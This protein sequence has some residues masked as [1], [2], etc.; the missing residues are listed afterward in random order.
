[1]VPKAPDSHSAANLAPYAIEFPFT[2]LLRMRARAIGFFDLHP[3][4]T[5]WPNRQGDIA[6]LEVRVLGA[7]TG[8]MPCAVEIG[9]I[10]KRARQRRGRQPR[11]LRLRGLPPSR[12]VQAVV[13]SLDAPPGAIYVRLAEA[14]P[15]DFSYDMLGDGSELVEYTYDGR[16]LGIRLEAPHQ[17][18]GVLVRPS[19]IPRF[20]DVEA[21]LNRHGFPLSRRRPFLEDI[22]LDASGGH[23]GHHQP[24]A[25]GRATI[26]ASIDATVDLKERDLWGDGRVVEVR[27]VP[28][29]LY[30]IAF[31]EIANGVELGDIPERTDL[32]LIFRHQ[33]VPVLD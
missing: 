6:E 3:T 12:P 30:R 1:M 5:I 32:E 28:G 18:S 14:D 20:R 9:E 10:T 19:V 15:V 16:I 4:L 24:L 7:E 27:S 13:E 31:Y 23:V 25:R 2:V 17:G 8:W 26:R 11:V 21:E 29:D 33:G 22:D